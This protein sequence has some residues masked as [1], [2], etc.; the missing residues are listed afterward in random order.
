MQIRIERAVPSDAPAM[1]HAQIRA[2]EFDAVIYP[3]VAVGGPPGYDSL[4]ALLTRIDTDDTYRIE[5]DGHIVG[6]MVIF[7]RGEGRYHLDVIFVDPD[8]HNRGIGTRA[9]RFLNDHY[10]ARQWTLDTPTWAVRNH[11]FYEKL[12]FVKTGTTQVEDDDTPLFA[13]EKRLG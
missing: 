12:G 8:Y 2:F 13:Y 5:V 10:A 7:D 1:L 11:H 9:M 6:G 3:G 4:D